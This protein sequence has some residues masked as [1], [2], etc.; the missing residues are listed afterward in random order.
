MERAALLDQGVKTPRLRRRLKIALGVFG[1]LL[2]TN[3][4]LPYLGLRDDSCQTMFSALTWG[5]DG[6][7]H[8]FMPQLMLSDLW[9]YYVDVEATI[10]PEPPDYGR[11]KTLFMWLN[12]DER[13]LNT[14]AVRVVVDQLCRR[15]YRVSLSYA[16]K[17]IEDRFVYEDACEVP[18]LSEPIRWLPVR[19]YESDSVYTGDEV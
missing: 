7:N 16:K 19:V 4:T 17:G 2:V 13:A 14:E 11:D 18:H 10:D 6:N 12:R 3:N 5:E 1:V 9:D 15:G 8:V